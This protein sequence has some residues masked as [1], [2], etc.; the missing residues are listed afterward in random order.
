MVLLALPAFAHE[1]ILKQIAEHVSP[2]A[3]VGAIPARGGFDLSAHDVFKKRI[4][5][6][7]VFGFQTLPW[8]CRIQEFGKRVTILGTKEQVDLAAWPAEL[9]PVISA[10]MQ[11]LL[12]LVIH[13]IG[14]FLDQ[15]LA[16]TGQTDPPRYHVWAVS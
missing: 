1:S 5:E 14:N 9:A 11:E 10:R 4:S 7:S 15:A 8:A 6:I 2:A 3:W 13:P 16:D 12:G